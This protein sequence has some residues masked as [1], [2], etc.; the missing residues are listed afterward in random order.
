M[1]VTLSKNNPNETLFYFEFFMTKFDY[2]KAIS[3]LCI[4]FVYI[5][6]KMKGSDS[7][8]FCWLFS[9]IC[10]L[11]NSF[12]HNSLHHGN[13]CDSHKGINGVLLM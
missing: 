2:C 3:I 11:N 13:F 10:I 7:N 6:N 8:L 12:T 1:G 4:T 9:L 5:A